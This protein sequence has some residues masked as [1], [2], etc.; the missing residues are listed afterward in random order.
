MWLPVSEETQD[1]HGELSP[2]CV[3]PRP[4]RA[5]CSGTGVDT[6]PRAPPPRPGGQAAPTLPEVPGRTLCTK[7]G[8]LKAPRAAGHLAAVI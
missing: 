5:W 4:S 7:R 3:N 8:S 6:A 1:Q 2:L